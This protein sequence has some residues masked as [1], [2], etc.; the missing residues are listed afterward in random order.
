MGESPG[1]KTDLL[2]LTIPRRKYEKVKE[3]V[4]VQDG[5]IGHSG[6][7]LLQGHAESAATYGT[8]GSDGNP[9]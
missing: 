2:I 5:N 3:W 8:I 4:P 1:L 7:H 9:N 6:N